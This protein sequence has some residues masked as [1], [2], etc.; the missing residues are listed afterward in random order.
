MEGGLAPVLVVVGEVAAA[1][2]DQQVE[3][4]ML[5]LATVVTTESMLSL[6]ETD[7]VAIPASKDGM[8]VEDCGGAVAS[9][10]AAPPIVS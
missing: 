4:T 1:T 9:P 8:L 2:L 7:K 3:E 10:A 5:L 6:L